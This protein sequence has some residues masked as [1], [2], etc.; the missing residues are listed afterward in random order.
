MEDDLATLQG[1]WRVTALEVDGAALPETMLAAAEI[2]LEGTRF[3]SLGMGAPYAGGL[4]LA[5]ESAPK[6]FTLAFAEGPEAGRANHGIYE[7]DGET[8]R[9]CLDMSGGPAPDAFATSPGSGRAL[10]TLKRKV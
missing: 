7:L 4:S 3:M 6:R 8:W 9:M 10:Q 1:V 5:T 2:R